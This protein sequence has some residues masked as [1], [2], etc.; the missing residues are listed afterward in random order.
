MGGAESNLDV[1][2]AACSGRENV[3]NSRRSLDWS[4]SLSKSGRDPGSPSWLKPGS[5]P[6][7]GNLDT[8]PGE[9]GSHT[10][11]GKKLDMGL[12]AGDVLSRSS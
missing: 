3:K 2:C 4:L 11:R 9:R 5:S 12:S 1:G 7:F 10:P 6:L 8:N